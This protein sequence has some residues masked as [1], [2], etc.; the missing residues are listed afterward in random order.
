[1][2]TMS[3]PAI[4]EIGVW[5]EKARSPS[6]CTMQAPHRPAPQPNF[7]PVSLSS[8]R[9]TQSRRVSG[10]A[11]TLSCLP[12]TLNEVDICSSLGWRTERRPLLWLKSINLKKGAPIAALQLEGRRYRHV[13]GGAQSAAQALADLQ[14]G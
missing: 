7:V 14:V 13:V 5:Q 1:M 8:S 6:I 2:V 10:G 4:V 9:S 3:L 11:L 12:L